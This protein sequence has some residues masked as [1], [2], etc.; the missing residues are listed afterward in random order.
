MIPKSIRWRLPLSYASIA[1]LAALLLGLVLLITLR[2]YYLNRERDYLVSS[3]EAVASRFALLFESEVPAD[4]L[5]SQLK[6]FSF[7]SQTRV[8]VLDEQGD[9]IADSGKPQ[10]LQGLV[11]FSLGME[12]D[13]VY[14]AFTQTVEEG[15]Q[16]NSYTSVIEVEDSGNG[17]PSERVR[18]QEKVV[19]K[20]DRS[21]VLKN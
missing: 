17:A 1:L 15:S 3:A 11:T 7:L 13:G 4:A 12:V 21:D 8:R 20:G 14:Q 2:T 19:I 10:E 6:S 9:L 5:E 16:T 18:V